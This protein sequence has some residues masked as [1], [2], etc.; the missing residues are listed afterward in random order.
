MLI[1]KRRVD[2]LDIL[3]ANGNPDLRATKRELPNFTLRGI[4]FNG[5]SPNLDFY[6]QVGLPIPR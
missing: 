3:V 2:F 4:A 6:I 5:L 1:S